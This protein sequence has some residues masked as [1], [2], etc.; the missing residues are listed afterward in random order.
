MVSG[1]Y[2][3]PYHLLV[4]PAAKARAEPWGHQM[5][6]GGGAAGGSVWPG[7]Q[8]PQVSCLMETL[9]EEPWS[10]IAHVSPEAEGGKETDRWGWSSL[11]PAPREDRDPGTGTGTPPLPTP[12]ILCNSYPAPPCSSDFFF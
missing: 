4:S 1:P 12:G 7:E 3:S 6:L 2:H 5:P 11:L 9:R 8:T 10:P